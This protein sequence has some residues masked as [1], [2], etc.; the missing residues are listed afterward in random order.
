MSKKVNFNNTVRVKLTPDG[1]DAY[2]SANRW[3]NRQEI[4]DN[5]MYIDEQL[6]AVFS[7]LNN[8]SNGLP[9]NNPFTEIIFND[10]ILEDCLQPNEDK[11]IELLCQE[12]FSRWIGKSYINNTRRYLGR[13][14]LRPNFIT[15]C[16]ENVVLIEYKPA[17]VESGDRPPKYHVAE[18]FGHKMRDHEKIYN[19][20]QI[21]KMFINYLGNKK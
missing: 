12:M 1:L 13:N 2:I 15:V 18:I 17:I 19:I 20:Y 14:S 7:C 9:N 6:W 10:S 8:F 5:N 21:H 16:V 11:Y 3:K 4:I